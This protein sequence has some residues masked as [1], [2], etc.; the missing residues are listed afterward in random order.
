VAASGPGALR[1]EPPG[2]AVP[3][4]LIRR[5]PVTPSPGDSLVGSTVA[6]PVGGDVRRRVAR[7]LLLRTLVVSVV[8]GL[9]LWLITTGNRP[10]RTA[11]WLQSTIIV[12]TYLSSIVFGLM[13]RAR[14]APRKGARPMLATDRAIT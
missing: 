5:D 2:T 7:L 12:A 8:L 9:S 10:A 3:M 4:P 13:L 11:V 6:V 1:Q 14:V